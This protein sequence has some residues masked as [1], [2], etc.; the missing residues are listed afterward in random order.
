MSF[1][2]TKLLHY[3]IKHPQHK[4]KSLFSKCLLTFAN[5]LWNCKARHF[6]EGAGAGLAGLDLR[7]ARGGQCAH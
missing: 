6:E 5:R 7:V 1:M 2:Q 3:R 4:K